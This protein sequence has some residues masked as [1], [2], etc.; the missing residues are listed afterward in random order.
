M[1][2][3][4]GLKQLSVPDTNTVVVPT[5]TPHRSPGPD[6]P[7]STESPLGY[8][9]LFLDNAIIDEICVNTNTYAEIYLDKHP[10]SYKHFL[11]WGMTRLLFF[12][13]LIG[14]T[15]LHGPLPLVRL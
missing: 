13:L 12:K 1:T 9:F 15:S 2:D 3:V 8:F 7:S 4:S 6:V 11:E 5:F 14:H 10:Y